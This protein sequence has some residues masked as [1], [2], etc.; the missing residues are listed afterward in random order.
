MKKTIKCGF[1]DE[2]FYS[3]ESALHRERR[4][5]E[6][7]MRRVRMGLPE[8]PL[9]D[10]GN[11]MADALRASPWWKRLPVVIAAA[12]TCASA[13]AKDSEPIYI[14]PAETAHQDD[15]RQISRPAKDQTEILSPDEKLRTMELAMA[16]LCLDQGMIV[17]LHPDGTILCSIQ[18]GGGK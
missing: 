3:R 10:M 1:C 13:V 2:M 5:H 9:Q 6:K 8:N 11:A 12:V 15:H 14:A 4:H 7:R 17:T 18:P 16:G